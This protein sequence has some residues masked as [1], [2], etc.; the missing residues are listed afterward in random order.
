MIDLATTEAQ[1]EV[2][3]KAI[4]AGDLVTA[5]EAIVA[6]RPLLVSN[7]VE[8]LLALKTRIDRMKFAVVA[9]RADHKSQLKKIVSTNHAAHRYQEVANQ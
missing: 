7:Q 6:L 2:V 9:Q 4:S 8:Q 1:L 5:S 3:E